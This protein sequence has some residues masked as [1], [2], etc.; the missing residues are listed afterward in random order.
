M[1]HERSLAFHVYLAV[2]RSSNSHQEAM[3]LIPCPL[4]LVNAK[5]NQLRQKMEGR[6]RGTYV[7]T[8][9]IQL[10]ITH[11]ADELQRPQVK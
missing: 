2:L 9:R 11:V 5:E 4:S 8:S 1:L 3:R 7:K 6:T 10:K